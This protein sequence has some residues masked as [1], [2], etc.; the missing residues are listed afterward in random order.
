MSRSL[1]GFL[2]VVLPVAALLGGIAFARIECIAGAE[3]IAEKGLGAVRSEDSRGFAMLAL[4]FGMVVS[5]LHAWMYT[6]WPGLASSLF[7]GLGIGLATI[8]CLAAAIMRPRFGM[9]GVPEVIVLN[10]IW[11]LGLVG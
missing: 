11:G 10:L 9:S 5:A 7:L 3:K 2:I 1:L 8:F 4:L 6:R